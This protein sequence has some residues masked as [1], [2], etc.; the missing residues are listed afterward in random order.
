M[1]DISTNTVQKVLIVRYNQQ[2]LLPILKV[3]EMI[4]YN[5]QIIIIV[6][7]KYLLGYYK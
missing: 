5:R 6:A 7:L 4:K 2:S 3:A 1:N